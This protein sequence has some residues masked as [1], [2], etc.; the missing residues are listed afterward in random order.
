MMKNSGTSKKI[1]WIVNSLFL[2]SVILLVYKMG[3]WVIPFV[4]A[5]IFAYAFHV[6]SM[7]ISRILHVSTTISSIIIVLGII[8]SVSLFTVFLVPLLKNAMMIIIQQLPVI[9]KEVPPYVDKNLH[10]ICSIF[11]IERTFDVGAIFNEYLSTFALNLPQHLFGVIDTGMTLMYVIVFAFMTPIIT[12]Y[13]LKDWVKIENSF[14]SLLNK[15]VS[16]SLISILR[17]VNSKLGLYIKGQLIVCGIL[18]FAYSIGLFC[19]GVQKFIVCGIVSGILAIAPFFG[20]IIG[21]ITTLATSLDC[22]HAY[23]YAMVIA[24]YLIIPFMDSNFI[25]PRFIGNKTGIQPV[26]LLF[27]ICACV[28]VLGTGGIFISVPMAVILSTVCKECVKKL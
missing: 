24:L 27:S 28:S 5:L 15:C 25:T 19:V 17:P 7:M 23:Q 8:T 13:L 6:P 11:G 3:Q 14:T 18:A 10:N 12:F 26:W 21:L 4:I 9:V 20:A 1:K 2:A 22:L 16:T